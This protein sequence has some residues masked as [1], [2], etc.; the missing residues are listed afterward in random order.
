MKTIFNRNCNMSHRTAAI[1][2]EGLLPGSSIWRAVFLVMAFTLAAIGYS[3]SA[4]ADE[5]SYSRPYQDVILADNPS[6]YWRFGEAGGPLGYDKTINHYDTTYIGNPSLGM[7]GAIVG[8]ADTAVGFNGGN[9]CAQWNPPVSL[10]GTFTVEAWVMENRIYPAQ[11]FF[12]TPGRGAGAHANF[13]FELKFD[14]LTLDSIQ[15]VVRFDIGDGRRVL[16]SSLIPLDYQPRVWYHVVAVVTPFG[17]TYYVDGVQIGSANYRGTPLLF[18]TSH[19]V[20]VGGTSSVPGGNRRIATVV[21]EVAVYNY[22]LSSDQIAMHHLIGN[23]PGD[24]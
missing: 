4:K 21:D 16:T 5:N 23:P 12:S 1:S 14:F 20:Q 17:A 2:S 22:G 24:D 6:I 10:A 11:T 19:T 7:P 18:D 3:P 13:T 15:K 9:Q 8:D